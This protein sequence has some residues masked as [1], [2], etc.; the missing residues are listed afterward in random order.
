MKLQKQ[1]DAHEKMQ[2]L[3]YFT[4]GGV[5]IKLQVEVYIY[6]YHKNNTAYNS[7]VF[8]RAAPVVGKMDDG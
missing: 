4:I 2:V 3:R 6:K 5:L 7:A 8:R 1:T